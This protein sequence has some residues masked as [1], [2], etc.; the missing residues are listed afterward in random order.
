MH[1]M[2]SGS[3]PTLMLAIF[4][5]VKA[6]IPENMNGMRSTCVAHRFLNLKVVVTTQEQIWHEMYALA[7]VY[8]TVCC[9]NHA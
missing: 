6:I 9:W 4:K 5:L 8:L 2:H 1:G 7:H 3:V